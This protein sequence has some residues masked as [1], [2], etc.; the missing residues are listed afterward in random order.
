MLAFYEELPF[1]YSTDAAAQADEIRRLDPLQSYPP[2]AAV[3]ALRPRLLDIGCGTGWLANAAA[4]RYRCAA[5]GIDFN[6]IAII[7][8]RAVARDLEIDTRF[9]VADLFNYRPDKRFSLVT[10]IGVLHH[11]D[12]C[13]GG[14]A[15]IADSMVDVDGRM[16]IG[17]YHAFGRRPFSAHFDKMKNQGASTEEL[18]GEFKRLR[19]GGGASPQD[20]TL[21]RSWFR[22]QVLHP[23][24]TRHTFME[25]M[26]VMDRLG[27]AIESTSTN[28]FE[29]MPTRSELMAQEEELENTGRSALAEGRYFPGFFL[30]MARRRGR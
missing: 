4:Y 6:P 9:E 18:Y 22:D 3:L 12:D 10:C 11:T 20:E 5:Y 30:F 29:A 23:H 26:P 15:H 14:L 16:F 8:A 25:I 21:M 1:N 19:T 7:R 13:L 2:V 17:L 28:H 27:F 24:E